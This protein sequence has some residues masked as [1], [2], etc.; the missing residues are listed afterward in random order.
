M[1]PSGWTPLE[2]IY[3]LVHVEIRW[4]DWG[5]EGRPVADPWADEVDG[6]W[7][8]PSGL[9]R[10]AVLELLENRGR[11]T[12]EVVLAHELDEVGAPGERWRG[13]PPATLERVL[14]HLVQEYARHAGHLD[15]AR[16]L[17]DGRVGE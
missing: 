10:S 3:H 14:L 13:E 2:L 6:R 1:V 16:E 17:I 4:L 5:F 12:R 11:R 9:D 8:V 15:I 7:H